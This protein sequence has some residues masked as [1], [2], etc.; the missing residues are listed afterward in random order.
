MLFPSTTAGVFLHSTRQWDRRPENGTV[1]L[2]TGR[3]VTFRVSIFKV[4][5]LLGRETSRGLLRV[6]ELRNVK[7]R[8]FLLVRY[9]NVG[10]MIYHS[11]YRVVLKYPTILFREKNTTRL[12]TTCESHKFLFCVGIEPTA[13]AWLVGNHYAIIAAFCEKFNSYLKTK[14][15]SLKLILC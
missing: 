9:C 1:P 8:K 10:I 14:R 3:M 5:A 12:K 2:K 11:L 15:H 7:S 4:N 6:S 13:L